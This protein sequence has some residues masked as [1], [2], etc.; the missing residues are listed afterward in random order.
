M[1]ADITPDMNDFIRNSGK[2]LRR[3]LYSLKPMYEKAEY[4]GSMSGIS[5]KFRTTR[6]DFL[7]IVI[8]RMW[9]SK[10]MCTLPCS[11]DISYL[12]VEA[13]DFEYRR[14]P[15]N[16]TINNRE[17]IRIPSVLPISQLM[18]DTC[19]LGPEDPRVIFDKN[20]HLIIVF[21]MLDS[22]QQRK[23][24]KYNISTAHQQKLSIRNI[25]T[26]REEKNWTPFLKD[27]TLHFV[28]SHK[29]L[30]ILRC[31]GDHGECDLVQGIQTSHSIGL[32][33]GGTQFVQFRD[34]EYFVGISRT[35]A[36]CADCDRF[37]RPHIVVLST[38]SENFQ[39]V[40][41][42]EPVMFDNIPFFASYSKLSSKNSSEFCNGAIR[43]MTPGSIIEWEWPHDKLYFTISIN[44][45]NVFIVSI[46]GVGKILKD[47]IL[48]VEAKHDH[49]L[50]NH[51]LGFQFV[52]Q[53]E[54][55]ALNYCEF[56]STKKAN[57]QIILK[58]KQHDNEANQNIVIHRSIFSTS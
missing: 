21:N 29:P 48:T 39:I 17:I 8:S 50:L 16:L 37:Y 47:I 42:S 40:Y 43:I 27:N 33:R 45:R 18:L 14:V 20:N 49:I 58:Q 9:F 26:L 52:I 53:S 24:W 13:L 36:S 5:F 22:D 28:Y 32:L 35:K 2:E 3:D 38:K 44:D 30:Q 56:I 11:P 12:Y 7:Y 4:W 57:T 31:L 46:T 6:N 25:S 34:T 55:T 23:I 1:E 15:F 41:V 54:E 10:T 19:C 51:V